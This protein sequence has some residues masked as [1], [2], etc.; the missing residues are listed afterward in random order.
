MAGRAQN[1]MTYGV[2][3]PDGAIQMHDAVVHLKLCLLANS[4]LD[5]FPEA[6]LVVGMNPLKELF[7]SGQT[8]LWIE[9]QNSVAFL[10]PVPDILVWTP[11]PAAGLAQPLRFRQIR[12]APAEFL[13]Q[14]LVPGNVY[15]AANVLFQA[16]VFDNRSTDAANVPDVTTG[17]ND[18]ICG[19]EG[20]SFRQDSLDQVCH[21]LAI[22]C[23]DTI[24]VFLNTRWFAG[25]IESV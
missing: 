14:E 7:E 25:R 1:R 20:R 6:G 11:C 16:F 12:L 9:T 15:G 3:V 23:V 13:G 21:G 4:R 10:R 2:N 18:A 24:Q 19:I 5:K 17:T 8:I 22:L